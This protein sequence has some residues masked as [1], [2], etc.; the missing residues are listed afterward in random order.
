MAVRKMAKAS[1]HLYLFGKDL[2]IKS[3]TDFMFPP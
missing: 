1:A 2:L 3:V